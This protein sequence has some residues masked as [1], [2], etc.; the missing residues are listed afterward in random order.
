[1]SCVDPTGL[2]GLQ[3]GSSL[4]GL[5]PTLGGAVESGIAIT[6]SPGAGLQIAGYQSAQAR[7]GAGLFGGASLNFTFTPDAQRMSDLNGPSYGGG[8]DTPFFGFSTQSSGGMMSTTFGI[9]PG[10][11]GDIYGS[12]SYTRVGQPITFGGQSCPAH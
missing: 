6:Y 1:M 7:A 11:A 4:S 2:W 5:F 12:A 3:I 9:G 10:L 8:V